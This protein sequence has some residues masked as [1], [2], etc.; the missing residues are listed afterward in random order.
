MKVVV[1]VVGGV[2]LLLLLLLLL[3]E[4]ALIQRLCRKGVKVGCW[5]YAGVVYAGAWCLLLTVSRDTIEKI[6]GFT[7][8]GRRSCTATVLRVVGVILSESR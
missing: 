5:C 7:G 8:P 2:V 3:L 4:G 6:S 1:T